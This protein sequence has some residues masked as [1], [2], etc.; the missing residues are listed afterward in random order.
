MATITA[1][2][3]ITI[4]RTLIIRVADIP[5]TRREY[6]LWTWVRLGRMAYGRL[7]HAGLL[8]VVTVRLHCV[9]FMATSISAG[10]ADAKLSKMFRK[11]SRRIFSLPA[12]WRLPET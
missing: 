7:V 11:H 4:L 2:H 1:H 6:V 9:A 3:T 5:G 8:H 10:N 12:L